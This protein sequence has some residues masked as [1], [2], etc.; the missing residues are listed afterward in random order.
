MNCRKLIIVCL[1][2]LAVCPLLGCPIIAGTMD[3]V[4]RVGLTASSRESLLSP[5]LTKFHEALSWGDLGAALA[6]VKDE[7]RNELRDQFLRDK[8]KVKVIET[9]VDLAEFDSD[10]YAA[11]V[12]ITSKAY[13]IPFYVIQ[14]TK[15]K[16]TWEFSLSDGWKLASKESMPE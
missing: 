10:G 8:D 1:L 9:S 4:R 14:K 7:K 15:S 13:T 11:T 5:A 3:S 6:M 12:Y 2:L 16:Q